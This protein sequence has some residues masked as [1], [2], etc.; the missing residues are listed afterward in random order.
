MAAKKEN[1]TLLP[2]NY[3]KI[4]RMFSIFRGVKKSSFALLFLLSAVFLLSQFL[5]ENLWVKPLHQTFL[6]INEASKVLLFAQLCIQ[7]I[8]AVDI[9]DE[10][11]AEVG[12]F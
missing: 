4:I 2:F 10:G 6:Q 3:S 12:T 5:F 8:G 9:A 1:K 11:R 7:V